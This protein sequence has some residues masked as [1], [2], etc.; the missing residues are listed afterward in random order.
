MDTRRGGIGKSA[1][2]GCG[3][4]V[5]LFPVELKVPGEEGEAK[6]TVWVDDVVSG[7]GLSQTLTLK[8]G[9]K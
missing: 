5:G 7:K 2:I 4:I 8:L 9:G 3:A 6:L 1:A